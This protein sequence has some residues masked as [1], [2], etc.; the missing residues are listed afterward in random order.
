MV[1]G[2]TF[3][4]TTR[5]QAARNKTCSKEC[6]NRAQS[7]AMTGRPSP[8]DQ[9]ATVA[10]ATCGTEVKRSPSRVARTRATYCGHRCAGAAKAA[11][12][13]ANRYDWTGRQAKP[14]YG[15][16]NPAWKGGVTYKRTRGNYIG[17]RYVRCP[18]EWLAMVRAD[19]YIAE[20]RLVM[21]QWIGR[22]LTRTECVNHINHNPRDNRQE[23][24]DLWPT[25]GDHKRGEVGRFVPGVANRV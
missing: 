18:P 22:P 21:A 23:N 12:L 9:R 11:A 16:D 7:A 2:L 6:A 24:L 1:C 17:P 15:P 3:T 8:T 20:H 10:C 25:N 19:G 13:V 14:R 5:E 4:P